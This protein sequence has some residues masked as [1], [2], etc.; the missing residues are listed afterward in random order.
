M[1]SEWARLIRLASGAAVADGQ[2]GLTVAVSGVPGNGVA[3]VGAPGEGDA[4]AAY[5]F[6]DVG[7][8]WALEQ[9]LTASDDGAGARFGY[10][11]AVSGTPSDAVA[12]VGLYPE[13]AE[14]AGAAY[15]FENTSAGE[16]SA[17]QRLTAGGTAE[18]AAQ[19]GR[20]VAISGTASTE[21][22]AVVGAPA[23]DGDGTDSGAAYVFQKT[24]GGG[25]WTA[26]QRLTAGATESAN[27]QYG[28]AVGV[29]GLPGDAVAIVGAHREG[30]DPSRHGAAYTYVWTGDYFDAVDRLTSDTLEQTADFGM[31]VDV[32]GDA[33]GAVAVVGAP[34]EDGA[35]GDWQ[36][37][38]SDRGAVY[39]FG[40]DGTSWT[41][42]HREKPAFTI[43]EDDPPYSE[44]GYGV[45]ISGEPG[46]AVAVVGTYYDEADAEPGAAYVYHSTAAGEWTYVAKLTAGAADEELGGEFG[47]AVGISG[48]PGNAVAVVGAYDE[49]SAQGAAYMFGD[50]SGV[51]PCFAAGTPIRLGPRGHLPVERL[52]PGHWVLGSDGRA[53]LVRRV[54]RTATRRITTIPKDAVARGVPSRPLSVTPN[55]LVQLPSRRH[56]RAGALGR[57]AV[58]PHPVDVYHILLD[59]W[60]MVTV[61]GLRLETCAWRPRHHAVRPFLP[62]L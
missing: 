22:V 16:W 2:F 50:V 24:A 29:S 5:V 11:V 38:N 55:H 52:R 51:V 56:V 7:S 25:S 39:F 12:I 30:V 48:T 21:G 36:D 40:F 26:V 3:V 43:S 18:A 44:F 23:E 1:A 17:G 20:A 4:G 33:T 58:C 10:S 37:I 62:K 60:T 9:Q 41:K 27:A 6:V 57:T 53:R 49:S 8:G 31:F 47:Y 61:H 13:G 46:D 34:T 14:H 35:P 59:D 19:F 42:E 32:T 45:S 54:T 28:F 15:V